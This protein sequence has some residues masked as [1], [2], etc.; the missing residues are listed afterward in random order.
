MVGDVRQ[1]E[2]HTAEPL[3]LDPSPFQDKIT[4]TKLKRYKPS[5][6]D[7]I[8]PELIQARGEKLQSEIDKLI[9]YIWNKEEL[10]RKLSTCCWLLNRMQGKIMTQR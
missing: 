1:T 8:L 4:I 3:V 7:Q 9:N 10:Q 2:I 6:S 5:G